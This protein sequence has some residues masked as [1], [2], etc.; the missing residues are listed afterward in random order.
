[1][2]ALNKHGRIGLAADVA[3]MDRKTAAKYR[4]GGKLPSQLKEP[5]TWR[6]REDPFDNDW[7]RLEEML[8]HAPELEAK[9]L[10]GHLCEVIRPGAYHEGQLRTLQRRVREWRARCGPEREVFFPQDHVPGR[11][12]QTDFTST[13]ELRVTIR[14][15][16]FE[17]LICRVVLTW[18]NWEWPTVC[19]SESMLALRRGVQVAFFH[20]GR[21]PK[22]HQTDNS[23]AA[24]HDVPS[25]KRG[26]NAD[27]EALM[28]HLDVEPRTIGIGETPSRRD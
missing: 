20:L 25:G 23:T 10:F 11:L 26:F 7:P 21:V 9:S 3:G 22:Q 19:R 14:G 1:M 2:E 4:D 16:A 5:R 27:Y 18:S 13:G 6:T 24:T 15:V 28:R 8:R 17:H 12:A